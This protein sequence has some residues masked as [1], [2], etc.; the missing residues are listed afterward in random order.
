MAFNELIIFDLD[1]TLLNTSDIYWRARTLFAQELQAEGLEADK[2]IEVFEEIEA[3]NIQEYGFAPDRYGKSMLDTYNRIANQLGR[4]MKAERLARIKVYG[5]MIFEHLPKL[6]EGATELLTWAAS[7]F[8]LSLI[9]RGALTLQHKKIRRAGLDQ[10]F[11]FIEVVE[12]KNTGTFSKMMESAGYTPDRSWVIGDSIRSDI[13][14]GIEAGATCILLSYQHEF[15]SWRQEHGDEAIGPYH[16]ISRLTDAIEVLK[17]SSEI[18]LV[19][20]R[21]VTG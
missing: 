9:T 15:Y 5:N 12:E 11:G 16:K 20:A 2:V 4:E 8:E 17:S 19:N 10:Y 6:M 13:N 7:H 14:P 1:D 3:F 21:S 18:M